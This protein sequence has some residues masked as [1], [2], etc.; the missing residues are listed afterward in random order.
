MSPEKEQKPI[1][2]LIADDDLPTR[3][4]LHAAI[5][6]WGYEVVEAEDGEKAWE[7]LNQDDP[8]QLL[9]LDWLMPKLDGIELCGRIR[10]NLVF[11]NPY[12]IL[13]T[14]VAGTSNVIKGLEA[15][16]DEFLT[17][18]FNVAELRSRL[19]VGTK[20]IEY[21]N[22]LSTQQLPTNLQPPIGTEQNP[23][24]LKLTLIKPDKSSLTHQFKEIVQPF[25]SLKQDLHNTELDIK[26]SQEILMQ[27]GGT[28]T[29]EINKETLRLIIEL[30][31]D[32]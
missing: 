12:I 26:L 30:P 28:I 16:A 10:K 22:T 21:K 19:A 13:L 6:Q 31:N 9:V 27:I 25:W 7:V 11:L 3:M 15:G 4:L 2:V 32:S 29:T 5:V 14:Q 23:L 1:K 18:P 8:P 20:I 24:T 17:K